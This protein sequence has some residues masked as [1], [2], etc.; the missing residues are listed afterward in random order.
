[1]HVHFEFA[2]RLLE[3]AFLGGIIGLE[4]EVM[5][6]HAGLRTNL[7][8]CLGSCLL[9]Q[10][11]IA[12]PHAFGFGDPARIAA[13]IVTGIGFLGAGT[14]L[15]SRHG[16]HGLTSAA[17]IWVVAA[18]GMGVGAG[19]KEESAIAT[20]LILATLVLLGRAERHLLGQQ[21]ITFTVFLDGVVPDAHELLRRAG[22]DR[23]LLT[24]QWKSA[25]E[26][27][28]TLT[29]TWRGT[30]ADAERVAIFLRGQAGVLIEGWEVQD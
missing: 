13:Q 7:L 11:S 28:G 10:I 17:T 29:F 14:I 26:D 19:M 18:V 15:Q 23:R 1:M 3:A 27:T 8:I 16:V 4:R 20:V 6:K 12:V 2:I 5:G 30:V 25:G 9:M 24:N 21:L 22:P